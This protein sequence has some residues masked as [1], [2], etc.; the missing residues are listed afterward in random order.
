[1][2]APPSRLTISMNA[3]GVRFTSKP[4]IDSSLSIVPP[5][6]PRPLPDILG[7]TAPQLAAMAMRGI[8]TV[9]ATPPDECLSHFTPFSEERSMTSPLVL[10]QCVS[11][12]AVSYTHLRAHET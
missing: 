9:S 8:D 2:M 10:M 4:G 11:Q 3:S 7:I 12:E 6:C 5:E 1:M